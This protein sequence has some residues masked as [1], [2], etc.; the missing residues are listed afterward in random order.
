MTISAWYMDDDIA[1]HQSQPHQKYPPEP[2]SAE[3]LADLGVL[4]WEGLKG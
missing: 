1:V 2:A 4:F 3:T